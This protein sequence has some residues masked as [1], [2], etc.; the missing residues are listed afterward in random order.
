MAAKKN[1]TSPSL[2]ILMLLFGI[3]A[4][5][6]GMYYYNQQNTTEPAKA[7]NNTAHV[8]SIEGLLV[9]INSEPANNKREQ[10]GTYPTTIFEVINKLLYFARR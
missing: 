6:G 4:G 2:V 3:L 7:D 1:N 9:F 5:A 8:R 10:L